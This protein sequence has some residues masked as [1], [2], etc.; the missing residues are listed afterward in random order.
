[1]YEVHF[2]IFELCFIRRLGDVE[3]AFKKLHIKVVLR[4]VVI[5]LIL[6]LAVSL[7][8]NELRTDFEFGFFNKIKS[9]EASNVVFRH[10][11]DVKQCLLA[12]PH[13]LP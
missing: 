1:M 12:L 6:L 9:F 5:T 7:Y 10:G 4:G 2:L 11:Y 3:L 8:V 13:A